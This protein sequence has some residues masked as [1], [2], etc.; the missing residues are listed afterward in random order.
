MNIKNILSIFIYSLNL[1]RKKYFKVS[2][3]FDFFSFSIIFNIIFTFPII[4]FS[5]PIL[6]CLVNIS[7]QF[8]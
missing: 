8:Y 5:L 4:Y 3:S 1:L 2:L 6:F 7:F